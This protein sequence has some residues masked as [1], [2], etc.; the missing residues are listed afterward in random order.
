MTGTTFTHTD[1]SQTLAAIDASQ[2]VVIYSAEGRILAANPRALAL[3]GF[4]REELVGRPHSVLLDPDDAA[5]GGIADFWERLRSGETMVGEYRRVARNGRPVMG[6]LRYLADNKLGDFGSPL[7][8]AQIG[9]ALA[10]GLLWSVLAWFV[11]QKAGQLVILGGIAVVDQGDLWRVAPWL[12][13]TALVMTRRSLTNARR[14]A[15]SA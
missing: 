3:C 11:G 2:C 14:S 8:R 12:F 5:A 1:A 4:A 7:A 6:D 10:T 15:T 13:L 9:A